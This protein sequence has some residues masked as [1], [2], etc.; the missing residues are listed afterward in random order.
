MH[1]NH[2][3]NSDTEKD[4]HSPVWKGFWKVYTSY[5]G[6]DIN[7]IE[8]R[9]LSRLLND[10]SIKLF[11]RFYFLF[12][13]ILVVVLISINPLLFIFCYAIPAVF[14]FH[15]Y[16]LINAWAHKTGKPEN[17]VLAN[18]FTAGEGWH[19]NHHKEPGNWQIGK[20]WW[21]VDSASWWIRLIKQ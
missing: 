9:A 15:G 2:H 6:N 12:V 5:W 18:I 19:L 8:K 11:Y 14:A 7:Y 1:H 13:I 21:Q 10:I 17:S 4:P 16:G 20:T 3:K